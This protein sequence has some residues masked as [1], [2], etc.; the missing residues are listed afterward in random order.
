M[1]MT[2]G[3]VH[4]PCRAQ[5]YESSIIWATFDILSS[6]VGLAK[7]K[8]SNLKSNKLSNLAI[9]MKNSSILAGN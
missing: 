6:I 8:S 4:R 7:K 3:Q 5:K 2:A 1:D 9:L